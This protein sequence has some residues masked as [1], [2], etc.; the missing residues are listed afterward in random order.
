VM[1]SGLVRAMK[2]AA[3]P[4]AN[5]AMAAAARLL[6]EEGVTQ[7][8]TSARTAM[9]ASVEGDMLRTQLAV[10]RRFLKREPADTI[11]LR[12]TIADAVEAQNRYPFN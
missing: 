11:S 6:I 12:R 3:S 1:E 9:A 8:E 2:T 10:L 5:P 7:I 4:E